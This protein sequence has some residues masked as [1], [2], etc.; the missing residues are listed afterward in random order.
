LAWTIEYLNAAKKQL[1]GFDPQVR[2][3]VV[4]FMRERISTLADPYSVGH[5]LTGRWDG[6]WRYRVGDYRIIC[7]IKAEKLTV[8]VVKAGHRSDVY[9]R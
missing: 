9:D 1:R 4:R 2:E 3:R 5:A 7:Q 8:M 6:H